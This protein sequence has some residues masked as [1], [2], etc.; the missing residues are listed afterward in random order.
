MAMPELHNVPWTRQHDKPGVPVVPHARTIKYP[1]KLEDVIAAC[2]AGGA[3]QRLHAAGS[4]WA[5]SEAAISDAVF[6]ETNDVHEFIPA[7]GRTLY[8]VVPGCLSAEFLEALNQSSPPDSGGQAP[9]YFVHVESGKRIYQLYAELDQG[10]AQNP[11]SLCNLMQTDFQNP[12]YNGPWGFSTLG[13]AGGQT[14]LGALTT[15]THGSDFDRGPVSD[16]V[17]ALHLVTDGGMHYWIERQ[18]NEREPDS[19]RQLTDEAKLRALY[20]AKQYGGPDK[21]EVI[22]SDDVLDAALVQVGRFGIVYS[23]VLEVVKQYGLRETVEHSTWEAVKGEISDPASALFNQP[24]PA[25]DGSS[26]PQHF[27][28][29]AVCPIPTSNGEQHLCG[30]SRRWTVPLASVPTDAQGAPEGR[31][32]RVGKELEPLNYRLNAPLFENAGTSY[33][34]SAKGGSAFNIVCANPDISAAIVELVYEEIANFLKNNALE[35]GGALAVVTAVGGDLLLALAP[36]LILIL[37]LLAL[38]LDNY[39]SSGPARLGQALNELRAGL[40]GDPKTRAAGILVWRAIA[41]ALFDLLEPEETYTAISY[42][43]LDGHDYKDRS[44]KEYADSVEV[45][46]D[47][48][49]PNLIAFVERVLMFENDQEWQH[50]DAVAG[51]VS[52][53][54]TQATRA[55]IGPEAFQRTCAVECSGLADVDGSEQFVRY[56]ETL[57]LDPNIKGILHWGQENSSTQKD[58]EFRFGD[59]PAQPTGPLQQWRSG[60]ARVTENGRH[61]R[62]SSDFTRTTGLEIVQPLIG[63]FEV[64]ATAAGPPPT[65]TFTWDCL[66]NPPETTF[67]LAIT[68]PSGAI[69]KLTGLTANDSHMLDA[70]QAGDYT[71]IL[72]AELTRNGVA[73]QAHG[74]LTITAA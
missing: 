24:F 10:D 74:T 11:N 35:I 36:E 43:A 22:Y 16:S 56:A 33:P 37:A 13:G 55:L 20:G 59:T 27:L 53:R 64:S 73:R 9:R 47:A 4:H 69:Q 44:C 14:V 68:S 54:F 34:Y 38:F 21:F 51:Y 67:A 70:T 46:F 72:T 50:G 1:Q 30:V 12:T 31:A 71:A 66:A 58:I 49:D 61:A 48:A 32:Q 8:A 60:L 2:T 62:F 17:L 28:T 63:S 57:A 29:L 52:L 42:A 65:Y 7:M 39:K 41:A 15:G 6:V 18:F 5:L 25:S 40:L 23:L 19:G 3:A 26:I 45:F